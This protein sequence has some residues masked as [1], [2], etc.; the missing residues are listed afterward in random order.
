MTMIL[1]RCGHSLTRIL[2]QG[3]SNQTTRDDKLVWGISTYTTISKYEGKDRLVQ[4]NQ[5]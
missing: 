2:S 4:V 1:E 5:K 3:G